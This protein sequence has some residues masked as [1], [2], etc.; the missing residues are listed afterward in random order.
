MWMNQALPPTPTNEF[1]PFW[2]DNA[3]VKAA[4]NDENFTPEPVICGAPTSSS[5]LAPA[6]P[7]RHFNVAVESESSDSEGSD[8]SPRGISEL[9]L[10]FDESHV[11]LLGDWTFSPCKEL[12]KAVNAAAF[13]PMSSSPCPPGH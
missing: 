5:S 3:Q 1:V 6:G 10:S 12:L 9:A 2:S 13:T 11:S 4:L 8:I 7:K